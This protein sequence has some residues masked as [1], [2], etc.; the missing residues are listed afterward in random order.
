LKNLVIGNNHFDEEAGKIFSKLMKIS[1]I[2]IDTNN[3]ISEEEMK[4]K[5]EFANQNIFFY[6]KNEKI[7]ID[8]KKGGNTLT[9]MKF[10]G[11]KNNGKKKFFLLFLFHCF[12]ILFL[13]LILFVLILFFYFEKNG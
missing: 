5:M 3:T 12:N 2:K 6:G 13:F 1:D 4:K 10:V 7:F 8:E 11:E 9:Y